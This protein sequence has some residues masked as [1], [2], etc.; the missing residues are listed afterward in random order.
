MEQ[1]LKRN[2]LAIK[3]SFIG[4]ISQ[5]ITLL[6]KFIVRTFIIRYLGQEILG[7]DGVLI[8]TVNMLSLAELG[9]T[10]AMLYRLYTPVIQKDEKRINALMASYRVIYHCI[11]V[12]IS[13]LG[14]CI[15]FLLPQIIKDISVSW[16]HI[17]LAFYLQLISSV[18]SYLFAYQRILLNADQKK[19][20]CMIIDLF[21]EMVFSIA[22]VIA[23]VFFGSYTLYL[24]LA[25]L[26][27]AGANIIL[28]KYTQK[29]YSYIYKKTKYIKQDIQLIFSDAK[30]VLANKLASYVYTST[31]N[32]IISIFLGTGI[33]G[34]LS[35][36]K[37]LSLALRG[38]VNSTMSAMQPLIGNYLNSNV[39]KEQ[40]YKTL[41]R[42]TFIRYVIAG[43]TVVPFVVLSDTFVLLWT[44][45]MSYIMPLA[46]TVFLAA[47][48]YIGCVYGPLGEYI[49][50][51]GLFKWGKY[52]TLSCAVTNIVFSLIGVWKKGYLGVLAAT[53]LSEFVI[54]F[55]DGYIIFGKYYCNNMS[56]VMDYIKT[57]TLYIIQ[58]ILSIVLSLWLTCF[59]NF[60]NI[61]I[62]FV[63][64]VVLS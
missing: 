29:H 52:A 9:I 24:L 18:C 19:T 36:Y 63:L 54:W 4:I 32:L 51:M 53:V 3:G 30:D 8:D 48:Y 44:G 49:F 62:Q 46:V 34:L 35:N 10:S 27:T 56:Y 15:S 20:L 2:E 1:A 39:T 58:V 59:I 28:L 45:N 6:S 55:A 42:Y 33:V 22:K 11:A 37:Y 43:S 16:I 61:L 31:D 21:M 41:K 14:I 57:H 5:I 60:K 12:I 25:I 47:D 26:Q 23:V 38:M 13:V 64:G 7:L 40:S 17:Y 50:G